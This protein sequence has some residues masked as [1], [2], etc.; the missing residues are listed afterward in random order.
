MLHHITGEWHG[1]V[2]TQPFLTEFARQL[3]GIATEQLLVSEPAEVVAR[4]LDLEKELVAL[5]SIFAHER[6]EILHRRCLY[7]LKT[8]Q[9]IHLTDGVEDIIAL[10]HLLCGEVTCTFRNC[11]FL[12]HNQSFI[13]ISSAKLRK[14]HDF[15][16]NFAV[17]SHN[18]AISDSC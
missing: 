16:S 11:R 4:V 10:V 2:I 14:K 18:N 8:I 9:G 3:G 7:L 12:C 5:L 1:E 13:I 17:K 15:F 6:G